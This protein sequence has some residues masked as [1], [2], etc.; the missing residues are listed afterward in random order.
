MT[1]D[2]PLVTLV[3][4]LTAAESDDRGRARWEP[5]VG[6][7]SLAAT[8]K[9]RGIRADLVDLNSL[10][11]RSGYSSTQFFEAATAAVRSSPPRILGL[12]SICSTYPLTLRLARKLKEDLPGTPIVLGGPQASA[13]DIATLSAFP[14]VDF[15][16]RG[17]AEETFPPLVENLLSGGLPAG[18]PGLTF[19]NGSE[20]RRNADAEPIRD[21]DTLP[22]PSFDA[23]VDAA[24]WPSL[25]LEIGRGCP[26]SCRFCSTSGFFR[27]LFRMKSTGHVIRQMSSLSERYGVRAFDLV[28]DMFTVDRRRVAEFCHELIVMGAPYRW[29][30]SARTDCVDDNLLK[31][32]RDAGCSGIFFGI[33]TG[34]P[35]LQKLIQKN[36]DLER[37]DTVLD[38][39]E[40]LGI[41]TTASLIIGY[42]GETAADLDETLSF[43]MRSVR[44]DHVDAQLHLLAPLAGTSLEAEYRPRLTLDDAP[45]A[46]PEFGA[47]QGIADWLLVRRHP[48]VFG[49]FYAFPDRIRSGELCHISAFLVNLEHRCRGLLIALTKRRSGPLELFDRWMDRGGGGRT[50]LDYYKT[51]EFVAAFLDF[52]GKCH[53]GR[54]NVAVDV[55]WRFYSE[56]MSVGFDATEP[57]APAPPGALGRATRVI[58]RLSPGVRI[59][60]VRGDVVRV[61]RCLKKGQTPSPEYLD[62]VAT[63]AVKKST[64]GRSVIEELPPLAAA[65]LG[66]L[67]GS[68]EEIV[69]KLTARGLSWEGRVPLQFVPEALRVLEGNGF[70]RRTAMACPGPRRTTAVTT[71]SAIPGSSRAS[72]SA[73]LSAAWPGRDR[74]SGRRGRRRAGHKRGRAI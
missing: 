58:V 67:D 39:C 71:A 33:E 64:S 54:G 57:M 56:L 41:E 18:V 17:E 30:C 2:L 66:C 48:D 7:L 55:M 9:A 70:I 50:S 72:R 46:I 63:V 13:T 25:P 32:M 11:I 34:S 73:G 38:T 43:F 35:R 27:R 29:S 44:R 68:V 19:R 42:P 62:R 51:L 3:N 49:Q 4:A 60:S 52:V 59:V 69:R 26:F 22:L 20:V 5:A 24:Q 31:L 45:S 21:L 37:A 74:T 23:Y 15:V 53:V 47:A 1:S 65:I 36:L 12:S 6:V 14:F 28:H 8:L 61:L 16:L 40:R 10:W